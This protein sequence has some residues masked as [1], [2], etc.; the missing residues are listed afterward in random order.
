MGRSAA[1]GT[2]RAAVPSSAAGGGVR[3]GGAGT[4]ARVG[5]TGAAAGAG[6]GGPGRRAAS[7]YSSRACR[8]DVRKACD[9]RACKRCNACLRWAIWHAH[10]SK[11]AT[12]AINRTTLGL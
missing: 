11:R 1:A 4:C 5:T 9:R 12:E 6:G 7:A 2:A 10:H 3:A 8:A